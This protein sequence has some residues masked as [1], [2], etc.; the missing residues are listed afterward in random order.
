MESLSQRNQ[1]K[2]F[3]QEKKKHK[4]TMAFTVT[5]CTIAAIALFAYIIN[6]FVNKVYDNYKVLASNPRQ[7]SNSVQYMPYN[8]MT[9]K[10]S[11]D[12]ASG[13]QA[14]GEIQWNGSYEMNNPSASTCGEYVIIGDIGGKEAY[15]YNGSDS[16][17]EISET[18]PIVQ[19]DVAKQG[20]AAVVLED[21]DSNEIHIYNPYDASNSLLFKIP[22][23]V[24]EDGYPVDI[25]LS[26]DGKKLV[27]SFLGVNNGVT[28]NKVTFYNLGSVGENKV[29]YIVGGI[30]MGQELCPE[31]SFLNDETVVIYGEQSFMLYSMQELPDEI[32]KVSFDNSIKSVMSNEKYVGF[33]LDNNL[34]VIYD[35]AGK[36]VLE[37]TIDYDYDEVYFTDNEVVFKSDLACRMVRFNGEVKWDYS[38]NKNLNFIFPTNEK[39]SYIFIDDVNIEQV[40]LSKGE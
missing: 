20:V 15:V 5:L 37:E 13:I 14:N 18:L 2:R 10:Y 9:L 23:N 31:V 28:Q 39:D 38:F 40:K 27:T 35:M 34:F 29:N 6:S 25:S 21:T 22:T 7:D 24:N 19:V 17:T 32:C 8:G 16:G 33:I 30:D 3:E 11:R 26:E 1:S 36:K 4:V 12:G